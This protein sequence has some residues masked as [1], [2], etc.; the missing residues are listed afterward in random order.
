MVLEVSEENVVELFFVSNK[1]LT[2]CY[3]VD[4]YD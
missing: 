3:N 2:I 4:E 1:S